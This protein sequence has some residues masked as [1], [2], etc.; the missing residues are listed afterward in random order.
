MRSEVIYLYEDRE[1]VTLTT[2][3]LDDSKEIRCGKPR[4]AVL[5]CPG[6]AYLNCSDREAEPVAMKF[7]A[8][9][10]HAFVLRYS[11]YSKGGQ[12]EIDYFKPLEK[13]EFCM[14][15]TQMR[16]IGK[17]MAILRKHATEWN[18]NEKQIA[19]CGFSAG[20][21]NCAMYAVY[22]NHPVITEFLHEASEQLR[23]NAMIL[24]YPLTDYTYMKENVGDD[25]IAK[26]LFRMSNIAFLGK[27]EPS[28][29]ELLEISPAKLVTET[30][31]PTFIWS[32]ATD[33]IVPIQHSVRM[34]NA[35]ADV[36]VPFEL[37][38]FEEGKHG[39]SVADQ[40]SSEAKRE[41]QPLIQLWVSLAHKWLQKRFAYEL[42]DKTA[43]DL[44]MEEQQN[45]YRREKCDENNQG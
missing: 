1:D 24:G 23:P 13:K 41:V 44:F 45:K 22:W 25:Q 21:H 8:M 38:I 16:E 28:E 31:P 18:I 40:T 20:A 36:K 26:G 15:P 9:G 33:E 37:H 32:T 39:L 42:P 6:G 43:M 17:S 19:I 35:L 4:P 12:E 14:Y 10:Y 5:I 2:Y 7:L 29:K 30:V 11:V 3:V 27:E 34:A